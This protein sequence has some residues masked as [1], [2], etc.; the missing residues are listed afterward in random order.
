[1]THNKHFHLKLLLPLLLVMTFFLFAG[2][3]EELMYRSL[4]E[5]WNAG[6][7]I[8]FIALTFILINQG[9]GAKYPRYQLWGSYFLLVLLVSLGV[10]MLQ[11][12]FEREPD[13]IDIQ[14]NITGM[15]IVLA[16]HP[17]TALQG[18]YSRRVSQALALFLAAMTLAPL[19]KAVLDEIQ[20]WR[21]FPVLLDFSSSL[22]LERLNGS[23]EYKIVTPPQKSQTVLEVTFKP[24]K[25][26]G[27]GL[28]YFPQDWSSYKR[29]HM[30]FENT[31]PEDLPITV[32]IHD[33]QHEKTGFEFND[34]LNSRQ[35]L[36]PGIS[37]IS[38]GLN[39]VKSAPDSRIMDLSEIAGLI[40]FTKQLSKDRN[41][42]LRKVYLE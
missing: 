17:L 18:A 40:I 12:Q 33:R 27:V 6:H 13:I 25:F 24:A 41:V 11:S 2:S 36:K 9:F 8:Y 4:R 20:A 22:Q 15:F 42:Y 38:I 14:R 28:K 31:Q 23:A 5:L 35:V 29:V 30:E 39:T 16:F 32:R 1:M 10:E 34:R 21:Q 7:I 3:S 37:V 19:G 26:S